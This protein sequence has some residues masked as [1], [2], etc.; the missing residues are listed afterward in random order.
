MEDQDKITFSMDDN[1]DD[2]IVEEEVIDRDEEYD[3]DDDDDYEEEGDE[4]YDDE[5]Y[6]DED[7]DDEDYDDGYND[8][9]YDDRLN[10]V[11]DEIAELKRGM[12][13]NT[14]AI[15]Q[16][17]PPQYVYQ[18]SAPPA[19]SEVV[20]YNE[21]SRLRDELAKN[22][23]N[24]EMQKEITRLKEDMARDQR[25]TE[26]QYNAEIKRLQDKIGELQSKNDS[27]A[28]QSQN[29]LPPAQAQAPQLGSSAAPSLDFDK[30]LSVNE[31]ILRTTKDTDARVQGEIAQLRKRLEAVPSAEDFN[32]AINSV[33]KAAASADSVSADVIERLSADI[34]ALRAAMNGDKGGSVAPVNVVSGGN[35]SEI[36][37]AELLRQLYEIKNVIGSSSASAVKRTQTVLDLIG[38]YKKLSYDVRSQSISFKDKL[39]SV[40]AYSKKLTECNEPDVVDLIDAT[41]DL[42]D[43]IAA[44]RLNRKIFADIVA[45]FSDKGTPIPSSVRDSA[46]RYFDVIERIDNAEIDELSD[47]LPDLVAERNQLEDNRR[48]QENEEILSKLTE[49]IADE[50]RDEG[51]IKDLVLSLTDLAVGDV[52]EFPLVTPPKSYKPSRPVAD[53]SV[54][55]KLADIKTVLEE[56]LGELKAN[57]SAAAESDEA[58]ET[59]A[60]EAPARTDEFAQ[61]ILD[62]IDELKTVVIASAPAPVEND[63]AE[64]SSALEEI[65]NDFLNVS[66][67]LVD[68]TEKINEPVEEPALVM[69]PEEKDKAVENLE[70][71][72]TKLDDYELFINQISD[73]RN[74]VLNISNTIDFTETYNAIIGEMTAQFD[75][76][77]EDISS[78]IIES[79]TNIT[80]KL[81]DNAGLIDVVDAAKADIIA[82]NQA[83]RDSVL[84]DTQAVRD[85]TV[86]IRDTVN[87]LLDGRADILAD[88][89][90]IKDSLFTI[91][92]TLLNSPVNE[93]IEQLRVDL[94]AF[95]D[96]TA[97][98]VDASTADRQ[99]LLDDVAFLREQMENELAEKEQAALA[100]E[101]GEKTPEELERE[102][103]YA[104]LDEIAQRIALLANVPDDV[105]AT[106]E[107]VSTVLDNMSALLDA[108]A[109]INDQLNAILDKLEPEL[110][111][112]DE[113]VEEQEPQPDPL[114]EDILEIRDNLN[115]ILDTLPLLPQN[116]DLV[117][118]RDN[119]YSILDTLTMM[120]QIDDVVNTRDNVQ[121][122]VDAIPEGFAEDIAVVRDNTGAMLDSLATLAQS[123]EDISAL[124]DTVESSVD[125]VKFIR[126]KL[127]NSDADAN[128]SEAIANIMNDI[129]MLLDR[130][131]SFEQT[132]AANKQEIVDTV[133]GVR[134]EFHI[135]EIEENIAANGIDGETRD[136]LVNEIADI[137]DRLSSIETSSQTVNE[138]TTTALENISAQL[139]DLAGAI[140]VQ[141]EV[142]SE[143][144]VDNTDPQVLDAIALDIA[145]IKARLDSGVAFAENGDAPAFN[146]D[147]IKAI[148]DELSVIKEKI[149]A[150]SEY[151]TV[152][153]IL[154]LREDVKAARIVDQNEVSGELE[155]IKNE[156]AAISSGN[157]LDEIRALREDIAAVSAV[158]ETAAQAPTDDELNLVLNEI[159]S[160]RDEVFAFKD[161]VLNS[162]VKPEEEV[163]VQEV[164]DDVNTI[165][166]EITSLR[167]DQTALTDNIDELK[168]MISR[169]TTISADAEGQSAAVAASNELNV[170]LDEIINLKS[171]IARVEE[172]IPTDRLDGITAQVEELRA[173]IDEMRAQAADNAVEPAESDALAE[174][175]ASIDNLAL[176]AQ[177]ADMSV[178]SEQIDAI[179][180]AL[181]E[182]RLNQAA[183]APEGVSAG[184][185]LGEQFDGLHSEMD[186]LRAEIAELRAENEQLKAENAEAINNGFA[187]L[188]EAIRDMALSMTPQQ[189]ADGDTSYAALIDEIRSLKEQINSPKEAAPISDETLTAIQN[190]IAEQ[191]DTVVPLAEELADIRDE[192]AQLRS[193]TTVA[194]EAGS[195]AE[196]AALR[197]DLMDMKQALSA[198]ENLSGLAEDVTAIK[199]DVQTLKEEPDLGVMNE[200][201]A[202]RD[203]FQSLREEIEDV[204]RIAG[205]TDTAK[206]DNILN[207]VQSLR[208]QLFAISMANVNDSASGESNYESYNNLI[209]DEISSLRDQLDA[210]SSEDVKAISEDLAEMKAA[211]ASREELYDALS[212]RVTKLGNDA[213]N[214]KILEELALLRQ[215]LANQRDADLTT[216]NF[217]SEM[218]HL[219]ERQN[220]YIVQNAG[221]KISDEI[222]SLKAELASTDNV[223]EEIEKL[224][225]EITSLADAR[226]ES[227]NDDVADDSL[228]ESLNDLKNQ[229]SEIAGIIEPAE[230][231]PVEKK[232]A[233][234]KPTAKKSTKTGAKRG[235]KPGTK[236]SK[237]TAVETP[238]VTEEIP[239]SDEAMELK[240]DEEAQK[241]GG[242]DDM[243]LD[244]NGVTQDE[245]DIADK[246]AKQVANKLVME[247]LVDQLA[248]GGV[249]DEHVDELMRDIL[250]RELTTVAINEQSDKVR[251]LANQLVLKKLRDRLNGGSDEE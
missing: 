183:S 201:L 221:T 72:R 68:I 73:L 64:L 43:S 4:E 129:G 149:D 212:E 7:Y 203:E 166:D 19:G 139:N 233:A 220:N 2:E 200:I 98:N 90:A 54:F 57:S 15:Q 175:K 37:A 111:P 185:A 156:L 208:D 242:N 125:D 25:F 107:T 27:A 187:E 99:K 170:V 108:V 177:P 62:A 230:K 209:L 86:A 146:N 66:S 150:E 112:E 97:A 142:A 79:E 179:S 113:V 155:S 234:K 157:I 160:L 48:A 74:D 190:A 9:Y 138:Y 122:L 82:D 58:E 216:L 159:V 59:D 189:T 245:L 224:R 100:A 246:L 131:E 143:T 28:S 130:L 213:T 88:T 148:V 117:T 151:D 47:Y 164:N 56:G 75:K 232:P 202:L 42:I 92:D 240:I 167:A 162:T 39:N 3:A 77:Y 243:S 106:K 96:L 23:S 206:D 229:L 87:T 238:A 186:E 10:K 24:L 71:I 241:L 248:D 14:P 40:Y 70:Y 168:D 8:D 1:P 105:S 69:T 214:N 225:N 218:A 34:S 222:E 89:Q 51:V 251:R 35:V 137:R 141:G 205:E 173:L 184:A 50:Q 165:L 114:A 84:A 223:A 226:R 188:R 109:P 145:D 38:E 13:S 67:Q 198:P 191:T 21:I 91:N 30:L 163:P 29:A 153:E 16:P 231:K 134:E 93:A 123:Q 33:K 236:N 250:P 136:A 124:R 127:E 197:N 144:V 119:T 211:I 204:K 53:D 12:T 178:L 46:D 247:Q 32:R 196:I 249:S 217:M 199:S 5:D 154:S 235:R 158:G 192:I 78:V 36:G 104:Y 237:N 182:I 94:S 44:R 63:N 83:T 61:E 116:D 121:A 219:L 20:M 17:M 76:L 239:T 194:A 101:A 193:L 102:K 95:A 110:P 172:V 207:E 161:E 210:A 126:E 45:Y 227:A 120:P 147:S 135:N 174:I 152:E 180:S 228:N 133:N 81:A 11:L 49:A 85:D 171:D 6:D 140:T 118:A 176:G 103:Q 22:Q 31:A 195:S 55:T 18:P 244:L 65:R 52:V 215:E 41:N 169:R 132:A 115:T 181:D 60:A 128:D 80:N 26:S